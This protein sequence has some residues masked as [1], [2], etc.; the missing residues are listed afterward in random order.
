MRERDLSM[1]PDTGV[2]SNGRARVMFDSLKDKLQDVFGA[3]E[4]VARCV[5][6][7]STRRFVRYVWHFWMPM[8]RCPL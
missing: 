5:N 3:L 4:S 1:A 6:Q 7:M 2:D 8:S